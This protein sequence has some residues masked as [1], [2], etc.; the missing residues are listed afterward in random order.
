MRTILITGASSGIGLACAKTFASQNNLALCARNQSALQKTSS[1]LTNNNSNILVFR[2]D[3]TNTDQVDEMFS[4]LEEEEMMPDVLINAAGLALGLDYLEDYSYED[5]NA[6]I[7]TNVTGLLYITKLAL[8]YMKKKNSG[9]I[10]DIGSIAGINTY[11]KGVIYAATKASVKS[12]SDGIRKEIIEHKIKIT[13]IQPGLVET[14]FSNVRF[15][16]NKE[17]ANSVYRGIKPLSA[18]DIADT[19]RY[20]IDA[21][22]HVQINEITVTPV[23]QATVEQIYK[24]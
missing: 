8:K 21:P 18:T 22:P 4:A 10:V 6:M 17:K 13:N 2:A 9:H 16:G 5:L 1:E 12:I 24:L 15:K 11:S 3:V 14:N 23:H 7:N 20:A 19:I